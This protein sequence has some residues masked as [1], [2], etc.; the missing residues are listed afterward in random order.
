MTTSKRLA[1][2]LRIRQIQERG[3]RGEL[4]VQRR[5]HR[6]AQ[7]AERHTWVALDKRAAGEVDGVTRPTIGAGSVLGT[8]LVADAGVRAAGTQH[9]ATEHAA[10]DLATAMEQWTVAARRVEGMERLADRVATYEE[11]ERQRMAN[12]EI[13]D[14]V[15]ARFGRGGTGPSA[16]G[17]RG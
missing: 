15:L 12:N 9:E 11:E 7:I 17:A 2:V 4:A 5:R 16:P 1:A 13:D 8:R 14:L 3:A 6:L 10:L